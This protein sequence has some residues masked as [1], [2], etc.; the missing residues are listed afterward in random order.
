MLHNI[1]FILRGNNRLSLFR[2]YIILEHLFEMFLMWLC[3]FNCS[4][5]Y[6]PKK[7]NSSTLSIFALYIFIFR[8]FIILFLLAVLKIIYSDLF[9]FRDN[10]FNLSHLLILSSSVLIKN[11]TFS[12][13]LYCAKKSR[14]HE[15][16]MSSAYIIKLNF[17]PDCAKSFM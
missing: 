11:S 5:K 16:V 1:I 13:L 17:G 15:S 9:T 7:L 2:I 12:F 3:Q 4:L 14:V 6:I 10:Q 8:G